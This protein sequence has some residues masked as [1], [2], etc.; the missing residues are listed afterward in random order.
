MPNLEPKAPGAV[1]F[2][3]PSMAFT[4]Q[5]ATLKRLDAEARRDLLDFESFFLG[6]PGYELFLFIYVEL[7]ASRKREREHEELVRA[8]KEEIAALRRGLNESAAPELSENHCRLIRGLAK[9]LLAIAFRTRFDHVNEVM[10]ELKRSMGDYGLTN[11]LKSRRG[12]SIVKRYARYV[13]SYARSLLRDVLMLAFFGKQPLGHTA[14]CYLI[15]KKLDL[16]EISEPLALTVLIQRD[17]MRVNRQELAA[18]VKVVEDEIDIGDDDTSSDED[19]AA[20]Q[21][22]PPA[23]RRRAPNPRP[24]KGKDFFSMLAKFMSQNCR[25]YGKPAGKTSMW[26]EYL[27]SLYVKEQQE[28]P[29]D[30]LELVP[31]AKPPAPVCSSPDPSVTIA[32]AREALRNM[33][34]M[35]R[36]SPGHAGGMPQ[37]PRFDSQ[38]ALDRRPNN[39]SSPMTQLPD[40]GVRIP[41]TPS[42]SSM[43]SGAPQMPPRMPNA[44]RSPRSSMS[45]FPMDTSRRRESTFSNSSVLAG[46]QRSPTGHGYGHPRHQSPFISHGYRTPQASGGGYMGSPSAHHPGTGAPMQRFT[47]GF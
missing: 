46:Q 38:P 20:D 6:V 23:K 36:S 8:L 18:R 35:H 14:T 5:L 41:L 3:Q 1:Q 16:D 37:A 13:C 11:I 7:L 30:D 32:T 19:G 26:Q 15:K 9:A 47:N 33:R 21:V 10:N 31:S 28:F 25:T 42:M 17:F 34:N 44:S 43:L 45:P 4:S 29:D 27:Q 22:H 40:N 12:A 39:V 2:H 24:P